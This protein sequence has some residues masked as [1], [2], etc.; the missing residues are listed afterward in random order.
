MNKVRHPTQD[1]LVDLVD[2]ELT[3][4]RVREIESHLARCT[5]CHAYVDSLRRTLTVLERW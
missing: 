4:A 3:A 2:G 5:T 1:Q